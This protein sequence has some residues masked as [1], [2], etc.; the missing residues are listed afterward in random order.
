M[1][2]LEQVSFIRILQTHVHYIA[3]NDYRLYFKATTTETDYKV[4]YA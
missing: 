3:C 4:T 1:D 2:T